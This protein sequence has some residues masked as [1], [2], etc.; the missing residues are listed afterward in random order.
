MSPAL[1]YGPV[2][3]VTEM[4]VVAEVAEAARPV[5]RGTSLS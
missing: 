5:V 2:D 4:T 1:K 3:V